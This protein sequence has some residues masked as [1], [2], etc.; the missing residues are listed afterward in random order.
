MILYSNTLSL[1]KF[2]QVGLELKPSTAEASAGVRN[3]VLHISHCHI[4]AHIFCC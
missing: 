3:N 2:P 4:E 1:R